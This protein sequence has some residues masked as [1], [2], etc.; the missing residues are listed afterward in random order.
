MSGNASDYVEYVLE[1]LAAIP[2]IGSARFFGGIGVSASG[3]QF[4]MIMG[5][6]LYFAV[7]AQTRPGYEARGSRHFQY[8]TRTKLIEVRKY[9]EV[10]AEFLDDPERLVELARESIAAAGRMAKPAP[11]RRHVSRKS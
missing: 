11:K 7:D 5:N 1:Q 3:R 9:Y 6:T 10:P 8:Q 4:A 2:G